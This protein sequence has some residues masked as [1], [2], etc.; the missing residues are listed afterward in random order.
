M[1]LF[2]GI[3]IANEPQ[4]NFTV[5]RLCRYQYGI[6]SITNQVIDAINS[7]S[8]LLIEAICSL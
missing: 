5:D 1:V 8:G 4:R 2:Y 3:R 6:G 7:L